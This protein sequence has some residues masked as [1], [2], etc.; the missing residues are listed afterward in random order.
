MSFPR[1]SKYKDSGIEWLALIPEHWDCLPLK[2]VSTFNDEVID[3][4]TPPDAEIIYVDISNVDGI[5]GIRSKQS[6]AFSDA[7][8]RARRRVRHGDVIVS[9]VRTYLKAIA[10]INTPEENLVVSTG[11][12]VIRPS[13]ELNPDLLG[14]LLS[15]SYFVEQVICRSTGV[16]Y[17][18]INASELVG[19]EVPIPSPSEQIA[20][21]TFLDWET[22]KIDALI[23]EQERLIELLKE[24]RQSVISQAVTKG[25]NPNAPSKHSGI[26]WLGDV[27]EHWEKK[28]LRVLFRQQKRQNHIGKE[29]LSV[30]RDYGVVPKASRGDNYNKTPEDLSLYQLV[31]PNDLVVNK[32][33]AWQGSLGISEHEGITSPDYVVF[34]PRHN[35]VGRFLHFLLRSKN[36][37]SYYRSI[38][39]GIRPSQ[40]RIEPASFLGLPVFLPP[41]NEQSSIVASIQSD[42]GKIEKLIEENKKSISL[43][44][45]RRTAL[46]SAAVTGQIDVR[47]QVQG[48]Q[49][50]LALS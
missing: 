45:E 35:E 11:F 28:P 36:L 13:K 40:W 17:P 2:C 33:K 50:E 9:T 44:R 22:S 15:A 1:Y 43:L 14:Y 30:F 38:S 19:I 8:S 18:A 37:V 26:E 10:K 49:Q 4:R 5:S 34:T 21:A 25:L 39:N 6:M 23:S 7:P 12:A 31:E 27:P 32:M 47:D 20:I 24:K 42:L 3:E 41:R 16:S 29:V 48:H 46:I